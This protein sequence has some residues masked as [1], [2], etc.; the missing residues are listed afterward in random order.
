M[1]RSSSAQRL[2]K[3]GED[4]DG[5]GGGGGLSEFDRMRSEEPSRD[6][7]LDSCGGRGKH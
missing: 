5:S 6:I 4:S 3:G 2:E 7:S 1:R